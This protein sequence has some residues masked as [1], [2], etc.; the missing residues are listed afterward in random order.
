MGVA[1]AAGSE[2]ASQ[3]FALMIGLDMQRRLDPSSVSDEAAVAG[4]TA[5][6]DAALERAERQ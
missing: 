2:L 3:V 1:S 4:L 5:L 6:F